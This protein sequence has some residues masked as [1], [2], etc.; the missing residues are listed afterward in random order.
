[1]YLSYMF[2]SRMVFAYLYDDDFPSLY[3]TTERP[4]ATDSVE[5]NP[6]C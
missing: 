2:L 3:V 1:M 4:E 5:I 6:F